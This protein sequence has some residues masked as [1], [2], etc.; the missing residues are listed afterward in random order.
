M[1]LL[2]YNIIL[3]VKYF[4]CRYLVL[5]V[6]VCTGCG[7]RGAGTVGS[8]RIGSGEMETSLGDGVRSDRKAN[9]DG[10]VHAGRGLTSWA[11]GAHWAWPG[12][13]LGS[14]ALRGC[15]P[16]P[17]LWGHRMGQPTSRCTYPTPPFLTWPPTF[18]PPLPGSGR[19]CPQTERTD[20]FHRPPDRGKARGQSEAD[21][22]DQE[23]RPGHKPR[24]G[25]SPGAP[26]RAGWAPRAAV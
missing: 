15:Q 19:R 7:N 9:K 10:R 6:I 3:F 21:Q 22:G 24:A 16:G 25:E 11:T 17:C 23:L 12:R 18:C 4:W 20:S 2:S 13:L 5:R 26:P 14:Q 1:A 8:F